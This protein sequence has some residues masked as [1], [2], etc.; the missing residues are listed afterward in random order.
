M[1][2]VRDV[3]VSSPASTTEL[4]VPH[5][6]TRSSNAFTDSEV[7]ASLSQPLCMVDLLMTL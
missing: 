4:S 3:Q 6:I 2:R 1:K 7:L 5:I